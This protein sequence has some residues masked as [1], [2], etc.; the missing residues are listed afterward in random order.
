MPAPPHACTAALRPLL[1]LD[2]P[3]ANAAAR[4]FN[5]DRPT[6]AAQRAG[7]SLGTFWHPFIMQH[8]IALRHR[9]QGSLEAACSVYAEN[10][11]GCPTYSLCDHI[12]HQAPHDVWLE[13]VLDQV[14]QNAE[15]LAKEG[16]AASSSTRLVSRRGVGVD[17]YVG[18]TKWGG[19]VLW[20]GGGG[21]VGA[22]C[23]CGAASVIGHVAGYVMALCA[24]HVRFLHVCCPYSKH[25]LLQ[26]LPLAPTAVHCQ[27]TFIYMPADGVLPP[28]HH[29][30]DPPLSLPPA[31]AIAVCFPIFC[32]TQMDAFG[33]LATSCVSTISMPRGEKPGQLRCYVRLLLVRF[34]VLLR[35]NQIMQCVG[36]LKT[37]Q[38]VMENL[39]VSVFQVLFAL[40][41]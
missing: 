21:W 16:D 1:Q 7:S 40:V 26:H 17:A 39:R 28:L 2:S 30:A 34:K 5:P 25:Y 15:Q 41:V 9:Q 24:D 10:K 18:V 13:G 36:M 38:P 14:F 37:L 8:L 11:Q 20:V 3:E 29:L 27:V 32:N 23:C 12:R 31:A 33:G 4:A 6:P 35:L 22:E 19:F